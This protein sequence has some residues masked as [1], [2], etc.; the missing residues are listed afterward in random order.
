MS[1]FT[2]RRVDREHVDLVCTCGRPPE[3]FLASDRA[4][5]AVAER[6]HLCRLPTNVRTPEWRPGGG[7]AA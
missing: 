6:A 5:I 1:T 3:R 4:A 2:L 7:A